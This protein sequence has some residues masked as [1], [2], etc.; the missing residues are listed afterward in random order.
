V[1]TVSELY[2]ALSEIISLPLLLY[3]ELLLF[4][5]VFFFTAQHPNDGPYTVPN[6]LYLPI[7]KQR[8][9]KGRRKHHGRA[10]IDSGIPSFTSKI[11]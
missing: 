1:T 2:S 8:I 10:C 6:F 3:E 7:V 5:S 11:N 9:E 4:L